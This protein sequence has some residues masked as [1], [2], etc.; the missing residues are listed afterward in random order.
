MTN[1]ACGYQVTNL[2]VHQLWLKLVNSWSWSN[3]RRRISFLRVGAMERKR[4]RVSK[5]I[6][7]R[8]GLAKIIMERVFKSITADEGR[9]CEGE[10]GDCV[11]EQAFVQAEAGE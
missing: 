11:G 4:R 7:H 10:R 3:T 1:V 2:A 8:H 6:D 9:M 5:G